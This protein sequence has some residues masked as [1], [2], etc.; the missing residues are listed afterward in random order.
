MEQ[1]SFFYRLLVLSG[2]FAACLAVFVVAM[3]SGQI[4]HGEEYLAQSVRTNTRS[5]PVEASR[6]IITD[7]NGKVLVSNRPI[8]TLEFDASL[9]PEEEL[10]DAIARLFALLDAQGVSYADDLPLSRT[11]PYGYEGERSDFAVLE[12]FLVAQKWIEE[13]AVNADGTPKDYTATA[14][15]LALHK[16]F[17]I[18]D[19]V[20]A[21]LARALIGLRYS[22]AVVQS[23]G[24]TACTVASDIDASLISL[25]KDGGFAGVQI[26]TSSMREYETDYAAHILGRVT[27][28]PAERWEEY[29]AQG[30]AMNDLVGRDGVEAAFEEYLRGTDGRRLVTLNDSGKVIDELYST[31]PQ[32]GGTVALTIDIDFQ[33]QVEDILSATC[34]D[35][36]KSDKLDHP[37]AAAVVQVGT[38]DVLAL[39]S[40]PTFSLA[41]FNENFAEMNADPLRPMWNRATQGTYAPGSTIKPLTAVA[42]LES[43]V[44]NIYER[45]FDSGK[46]VY[47][48][49]SASY[50][51]CWNRGG[52]GSLNVTGA[53]TNSCNYFF[54]EMGYRLGMD[55][56]R[57]Y[58]S[59][60]GLG[61]HT[62]I[63]IGDEAGTLPSQEEG[64]NLAPWAAYGQ[65]NQL[66]TPL[67][68]ASYIATLAGGGARYTPHLL[69]DVREYDNASLLASYNVPPTET[70]PISDE[71]LSAVLAGM[72]GLV[73]TG[74]LAYY[75]KDCIV[76]AAAKTGT[77]QTSDT[78][79]DNG[80]FVCFAPYDD[81]QIAVA[82]VIEKG[83]KGAALAS[84]AVEI[85]NAWFSSADEG[86]A[87]LGENTLL[88]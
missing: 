73:T 25:L 23:A 66:Y 50:T 48:G 37:A 38:G 42:S 88:K 29:K 15:F 85:L 10:N 43:G 14:L 9:V 61:E 51:Y 19:I 22:L 81:P 69:K 20:S 76:D 33:Q 68:L 57:S 44:T 13:G 82:L 53:I 8:Y 77:A 3:F 62:G 87:V 78:K 58:F 40:Y 5:E 56:L 86:S 7:R 27:K 80:V 36:T 65:A 4:V 83:Q 34:T 74:S 32:P 26:G 1:K 75:F 63:E 35:M 71:N 55:R 47:P 84:T 21:D 49:Y 45:I 39:A 41:E 6:G 64:I 79:N 30:Y 46:W 72:R 54:A 24:Y 67:Q 18:P 17:D 28:I 60:F 31:E 2:L 11:A 70:V 52:H 59:A 16:E 12:K